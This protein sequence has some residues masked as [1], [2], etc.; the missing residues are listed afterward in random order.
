VWVLVAL[1]GVTLIPVPFQVVFA[2]EPAAHVWRLDGRLQVN[3]KT[4]N[5]KG[6][7]SFVAIGRPELFGETL[8][9][10][11]RSDGSKSKNVRGG[12]YTQ[13][14]VVAEPLAAAA[15]LS[16]AGVVINAS[17]VLVIEDRARAAPAI[18]AVAV[19]GSV[20]ELITLRD[21]L[22]LYPLDAVVGDVTTFT[23]RN[24]STVSFTREELQQKRFSS[25]EVLN[26]DIAS[27]IR[28]RTQRYVPERWFRSLAV[29][30]SH[31]F[32]VAL[33]TYADA[34][35]P[36]L[37]RGFHIAGTGAIRTDGTVLPVGGITAK[38]K[39]AHRAGADV[40]FYPAQHT[41]SVEALTLTGMAT[42][43]VHHLGDAVL[44]LQEYQRR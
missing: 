8:V 2:D 5:P 32:M 17:P 36:T 16:Y 44:W 28:W 40:F 42:V 14:P 22:A 38:A 30:N 27:R 9:N 21:A 29:G 39:A 31:G 7:W 26:E 33:V 20:A 19:N 3:G 12:P 13:R 37:G 18:T 10:M 43:P 23:L 34:A 11:L 4:V 1:L 6:R 35:D 15:G 25:S 24:G 41:D